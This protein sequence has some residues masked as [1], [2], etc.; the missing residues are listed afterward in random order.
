MP[1]KIEKIHNLQQELEDLATEKKLSPGRLKDVMSKILILKISG[2]DN[3]NTILKCVNEVG[4]LQGLYVDRKEVVQKPDNHLEAGS[5][6]WAAAAKEA[7]Q[8]R[9]DE[10]Q[11]TKTA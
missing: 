11:E 2:S 10:L 9:R 4:K 7:A 8:K 1:R 3:L 5:Q 6:D